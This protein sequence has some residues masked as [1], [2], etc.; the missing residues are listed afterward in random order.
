MVIAITTHG[1]TGDVYPL[2]RLSLTLQEQGHE[3][4]FA[5][6]KPFKKEVEHAGIDFYQI[7][8]DWEMEELTFWMGRL[9]N[10]KSPVRQLK[11]LYKAAAPHMEQIIDAMDQVLEGADCLISSY[12]FPMNKAIADKHGL[13]FISYAFAHNSVPSRYYAPHGLP[14]LRGMPD[15]IQHAWNRFA[16]Q[17]GNIAVDTAINQTISKQLKNKGLPR[18]KDFFSKP[19]ELVLV[20]VSPELMRPKTKLN[21]RFQFTGYCRWQSPTSEPAEERIKAFRGDQLVPVITF[22][23]MVYDSPDEYINRLVS[24]WPSNRKLIIQP[25]WSGFKVPPS[26]KNIL[27]VG[28][29]SH[30][31]LFTHASLVIHHGGAGTTASVLHAGKPHI[32]VPHIGD[33]NFFCSEVVRL[34]CGIRCRKKHWPEKL[35]D[36]VSKIEGDSRYLFTPQ[37]QMKVLKTE[38]GPMEASN[39]IQL[40]VEWKKSQIG[41][42]LR[43]LEDL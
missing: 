10:L 31:Q 16:W 18:V 38:N 11:E 1:S 39:Q 22:G 37:E 33:Q 25:G 4:R 23:S 40:F 35:F 43:D 27:E 14:R 8:P 32:V 24:N 9:Q 26:A 20:A 36:K 34:G 19:A 3:V 21:P 29:M 30:D 17:L 6:S 2:I 13:P 7:P 28:K 5:T 41:E 12:L 15:W 42:P